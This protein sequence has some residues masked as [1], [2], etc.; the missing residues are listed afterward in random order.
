[1]KRIEEVASSRN[2]KLWIGIG[3]GNFDRGSY[4]MRIFGEQ[5]L[6]HFHEVDRMT[7]VSLT[8]EGTDDGDTSGLEWYSDRTLRLVSNHYERF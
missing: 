2:A 6:P 7:A 3:R 4:H 8:L 1:M 5:I